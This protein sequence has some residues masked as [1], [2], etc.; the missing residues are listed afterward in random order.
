MRELTIR[1]HV[2]G[3]EF[4]SAR[5]GKGGHC[6]SGQCG[7]MWQGLI[8]PLLQSPSLQHGANVSTPA[9]STPVFWTVPLGLL[10]QIPL[11]TIYFERKYLLRN[12]E[13]STHWQRVIDIFI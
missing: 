1:H 4:K 9:F 6:R 13:G 7:T 11:N 2:A 3:M 10:P 8:C 12:N 5:C